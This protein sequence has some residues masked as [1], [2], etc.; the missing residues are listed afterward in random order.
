M[1]DTRGSECC[2]TPLRLRI[3][4]CRGTRRRRLQRKNFL[5]RRHSDTWFRAE[6]ERVCSGR[7][8]TRLWNRRWC[9]RT[10]RPPRTAR[11]MRVRCSSRWRRSRRLPSGDARSCRCR[12]CRRCTR[13]RRHNA[14]RS[15]T[16]GTNER[17]HCSA[18]LPRGI[19]HLSNKPRT[20]VSRSMYRTRRVRTMRPTTLALLC[21]R[22]R[23]RCW[24]CTGCRLRTDRR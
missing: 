16:A 9:R 12:S 18:T 15:C 11:T 7:S 4:S 24:L 23:G 3:A 8:S 21:T 1:R 22:L 14:R 19:E 5:R 10:D 13:C 2:S 20:Q 6:P 17:W